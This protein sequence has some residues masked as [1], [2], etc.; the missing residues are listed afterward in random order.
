MR[1]ALLGLG[2]IGT[3]L[4]ERLLDGEHEL[5]VW[6]RTPE[7]AEPLR[8]SGARVVSTS[9]EAVDGVDV[10]MTMLANDDAVRA[11]ALG[12][13]GFLDVLGDSAVYVDCS[14]IAPALS[15]EL[16]TAAGPNRFLAMA[17]AGAP[18]AVRTGA[19]VYLAGGPADVLERVQPVTKTLGGT[20]RRFDRP[21]EALS[22]KLANNLML[23]AGVMALAEAFEVGRAGGL[24][25]DALRK[26]LADNPTVPP[27]LKNRF[28]GILTGE[29]ESWW[30]TTLGAKDAALMVDHAASAGVDLPL[31]GTVRDGLS[32][33]AERHPDEDI[34]A[35]RSNY[36]SA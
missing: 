11:V 1:V 2:R 14:T 29:H 26:L 18:Q 25:D 4:A 15:E 33:A 5:T 32:R 3:A 30:T 28:D 6:N 13:A 19:A 20:L 24:D 34:V 22:A 21:R 17:I 36:R 23:L 27:A 12:D 7:K 35:I 31:T 9:R 10:A 16:A 8:E